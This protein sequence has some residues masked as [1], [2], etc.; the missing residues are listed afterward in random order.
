MGEHHGAQTVAVDV[1]I[2]AA[3]DR[4]K[5]SWPAAVAVRFGLSVFAFPHLGESGRACHRDVFAPQLTA[6]AQR[7]AT[8]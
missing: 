5:C 8:L 2:I 1:N 6:K 3:L 4:H 7:F